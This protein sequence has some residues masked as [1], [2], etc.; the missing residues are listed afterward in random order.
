M[1]QIKNEVRMF[2]PFCETVIIINAIN[3]VVHEKKYFS[4][5]ERL[6]DDLNKGIISERLKNEFKTKGIPLSEY[7]NIIKDREDQ[8][9]ITDKKIHIAKKED[10]KLNVYDVNI[11]AICPIL[12]CKEEIHLR[13]AKAKCQCCY[14][15]YVYIPEGTQIL[16]THYIDTSCKKCGKEERKD[17]RENGHLFRVSSNFKTD[18]ENK[19]ISEDLKKRFKDEK[20]QL[21]RCAK[22]SP[23]NK[24]KWEIKDWKKVYK[25]RKSKVDD[26]LDIYGKDKIYWT[27]CEERPNEAA[28]LLF[29]EIETKC[30]KCEGKFHI[31]IIKGEKS[32]CILTG[33]EECTGI[34]QNILGGMTNR[35]GNFCQKLYLY[36]QKEFFGGCTS[37]SPSLIKRFGELAFCIIIGMSLAT[38]YPH[39]IFL[40]FGHLDPISWQYRAFWGCLFSGGLYF[41]FL[42][43]KET[44]IVCGELEL[45]L[46]EDIKEDMF[47]PFFIFRRL[48]FGLF[49]VIFMGLAIADELMLYGLNI[50]IVEVAKIRWLDNLSIIGLGVLFSLIIQVF[51]GFGILIYVIW[52]DSQSRY[53]SSFKTGFLEIAPSIEKLSEIA[54]HTVLFLAS[55]VF[56]NAF[57]LNYFVQ[58]SV[59][60]QISSERAGEITFLTEVNFLYGAIIIGLIII[61]PLVLYFLYLGKLTNNLK[62]IEL[63]KIDDKLKRLSTHRSEKKREDIAREKESLLSCRDRVSKSLR[64]VV[65]VEYGSRVL[66]LIFIGLIMKSIS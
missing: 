10:D 17:K 16:E 52:A 64:W 38:L 41:S 9:T 6:E 1:P 50:P 43:L 19:V 15:N 62:A 59:L 26:K 5:D 25:I 31:R 33:G 42:I 22:T 12:E 54:I 3:I 28:Y 13:R 45:K 63:A 2:C 53:G 23:V 55:A 11:T 35:F 39:I 8:W 29:R 40:I 61:M 24:N 32:T 57:F 21:S 36:F 46:R 18:L 66:L 34:N 65:G 20:H 14:D 56:L 60:T 30:D 44:V 47:I 37:I 49:F 4:I 7:A 27:K 48:F 51:A 58:N